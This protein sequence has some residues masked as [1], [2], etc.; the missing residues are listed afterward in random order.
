MKF[1]PFTSQVLKDSIPPEFVICRWMAGDLLKLS[2]LALE[3]V[4]DPR[5]DHFKA[6]TL[7]WRYGL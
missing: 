3:R 2:D 5:P 6:R 4:R 1:V 7:A